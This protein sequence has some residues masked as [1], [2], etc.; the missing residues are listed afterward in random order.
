MGV[1]S[2]SF[3]ISL[4]YR[5]DPD[6]RHRFLVVVIYLSFLF[7]SVVPIF[8]HAATAD[9]RHIYDD[10]ALDLF[11]GIHYACVNPIVTILGLF[12]VYAQARAITARPRGSGHG[13]LSLTGLAM[14]AVVFA[15]LAPLWLGRL[16]Y[17]WEEPGPG[18][19]AWLVSVIYWFLFGG[20]VPFDHG[21][22][23]I[24]QAALVGLAMRHRRLRSPPETPAGDTPAGEDPT[25]RTPPGET[26]ALLG[27]GTGPGETQRYT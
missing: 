21:V 17:K 23:A 4:I 5:S 20:F 2:S 13:A 26:D 9:P 18:F 15:L 6:V 19:P 14:Q 25:G 7:I 27:G 10:W 8:I 22:F 16:V 24:S 11:I 12:A 1:S 3:A